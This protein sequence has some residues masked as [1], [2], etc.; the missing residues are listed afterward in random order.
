MMHNDRMKEL[1]MTPEMAYFHHS[2][3]NKMTEY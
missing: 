2:Y 1:E 3:L